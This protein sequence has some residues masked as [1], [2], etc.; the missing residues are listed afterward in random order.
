MCRKHLVFYLKVTLTLLLTSNVYA[1]E[2]GS[3][4]SRISDISTSTDFSNLALREDLHKCSTEALKNRQDKQ[5]KC[6]TDF[7]SY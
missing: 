3:A 5:N 6:L 4:K 1:S 2:L 7:S